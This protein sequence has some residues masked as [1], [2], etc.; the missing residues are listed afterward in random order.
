MRVHSV[1]NAVSTVASQDTRHGPYSKRSEPA[2]RKYGFTHTIN[3]YRGCAFACRY[4][5][6]RYTHEWL[7]FDGDEDFDRRIRLKQDLARTLAR[8]LQKLKRRRDRSGASSAGNHGAGNHSV[9]ERIGSIAIGTAT[10]PYQPLEREY[11]LTRSCLEV[12]AEEEGWE[13]EITTKSNLILRD[14]ELLERVAAKNRLTIHVTITTLDRA[15]ARILEPGAPSPRARIEAVAALTRAGLRVEPFVSP[16]IPGITDAP[17][18]LEALFRELAQVGSSRVVCE[19]IFL[20]SPTKEVFLR[21][22]ENEFPDLVETYRRRFEESAFLSPVEVERLRGRVDRL[23]RRFGLIGAKGETRAEGV[24]EREAQ[25][26]GVQ[27][28]SNSRPPRRRGPRTL[29][30]RRVPESRPEGP[31]QLALT[32]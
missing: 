18:D 32:F 29:P 14:L 23:R 25:N 12:F 21:T 4:C 8:D 16:L 5:Y 24:Q 31:Q 13:L 2:H 3:P 17:S 11:G 27:A 7:G 20:R 10:D 15:L 6:A 22:L 1:L 26:E 30:R 9:G 19:A 28:A